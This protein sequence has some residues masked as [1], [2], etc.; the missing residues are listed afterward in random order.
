MKK[1]PLL[2]CCFATCGA[3]GQLDHK[4]TLVQHAPGKGKEVIITGHMK[5]GPNDSLV[6][7]WDPYNGRYDSSR[8]KNDRFTLKVPMENGGSI[9]ILKLG[10]NPDPEVGAAIAYIEAGNM[11]IAGEG[12]DLRKAKWTGDKWVQEWREVW[13]MIDPAREP[14]KTFN[15]L[16]A[17]FHQANTIGDEDAATEYD[18]QGDSI[19]AI[20]QGNMKTWIRKHPESGVSAYLLS[21]FPGKKDREEII[22]MLG[23]H[24]KGSRIYKRLTDDSPDPLPGIKFESVDSTA[25]IKSGMVIAG[26]TAPDFS[27]PDENGNLVSLSQ[28]KGKYVFIDFWASWC[29]PCKPQIPFLKAAHEKFRNGNFVMLAVSLD[30]DKAAWQNAIKKHELNWTNLSSL[31]G[32]GE[33]AAL[34]YGVGYVPFN[35]LIGPDGKVLATGLYGADIDKKLSE[36]IK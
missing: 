15:A 12:L 9:F 19:Q 4:Q 35:V 17:K 13:A 10:T 31:K 11:H 25:A 22:A 21:Y 29:G 18:R 30:K 16:E 23:D 6:Q 34:A 33:P 36:L 1:I 26:A 28:F 5:N 3:F 20:Y 2:L 14:W 7:V 32:W 27:A 24:A 8:M